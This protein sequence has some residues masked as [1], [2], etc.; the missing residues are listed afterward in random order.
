MSHIAAPEA[1]P[2]QL[3]SAKR[4]TMLALLTLGVFIAFIDRTIISSAIADKGFVDFFKLS[5]I[6]RG[7][8]GSAFF[9]SY[10]IVQLPMG[11]LVDRYGVKWPYTIC[12]TL[13]C[14]AT[15]LTGLVSTFAAIF[16]MRLLVGVAESV[17][18]PAS[19]R[20]IRHNVPEEQR[21]TMV[22]IF[23]MGNKMGTAVGAPLAAWLI[24]AYD[25]RMMFIVLG[26]AGIIWVIPWLTLA[27][28]DLLKGQALKDAKRS[29]SSVPLSS[30][31]ASPLVLGEMVLNFC[32]GYF[33]FFCMTWMPSYLSET[34]GLSL[35]DSALFTFFSFAGIALVAVLSG[36][37][38]DRIIA[39]GND[40]PFVRKAF[41]ICGFFGG[42][43]I[44]FGLWA[45]NLATALFWN[46][47]SLSF[48]GLVT[49][50][51]LALS[52]LTLIPAPAVGLVTGVQQ[53]ATSLSG[54]FSASLTGW[55]KHVT[56]SYE[57]PIAVMIV[58]MLIGAA[59]T[60]LLLRPEYAPKIKDL[61]AH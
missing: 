30:I 8:I 45:D 46:I 54:G 20:W 33:T 18:I 11:W 31:L 47:T 1:G 15:A 52:R 39:R 29:A 53:V 37:A 26:I 3:T 2:S 16:V 10:A 32:Y 5:D 36:W 34:R 51:N 4:W 38:A 35:K 24:T 27:E 43:T 7:W 6:D 13:W 28:N 25:W 59:A 49:A 17:V 14:A 22:G 44:I 9:W 60:W 56:G 57:A 40:A 19:Y 23:A 42:C 21:G 41:I 12:F 48:L 50:N 61:G 58:F 55:L